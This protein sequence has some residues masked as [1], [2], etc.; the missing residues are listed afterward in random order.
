MSSSRRA[1]IATPAVR[2]QILSV[3]PELMTAVRLLPGSLLHEPGCSR[4]EVVESSMEVLACS[5]AVRV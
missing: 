2:H 3:N 5:L 1:V 4:V